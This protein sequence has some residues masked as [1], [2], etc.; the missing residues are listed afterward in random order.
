MKTKQVRIIIT[1]NR[2]KQLK[3]RDETTITTT[4][5]ATKNLKKKKKKFKQ[6]YARPPCPDLEWGNQNYRV[7]LDFPLVNRIPP[8]TLL[9]F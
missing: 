4:T 8:T 7:K 1:K 9:K 3:R 6:K 2:K 5:A